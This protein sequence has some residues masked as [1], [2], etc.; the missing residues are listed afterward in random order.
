MAVTPVGTTAPSD[1]WK[2]PDSPEPVSPRSES[3]ANE[4][5]D[6]LNYHRPIRGVAGF[7]DGEFSE[8]PTPA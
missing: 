4:C 3:K 1:F 7:H 2:G 5:S 6:L 8:R